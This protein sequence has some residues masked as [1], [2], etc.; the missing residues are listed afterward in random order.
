MN[1]NIGIFH[2]VVAEIS[3]RGTQLE[4]K[5]NWPLDDE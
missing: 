2:F 5:S 1:I 3:M 4:E